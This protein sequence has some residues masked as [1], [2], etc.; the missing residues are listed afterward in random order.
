MR[1]I[2]ELVNTTEPGWELVKDWI[3]KAKN[4]I[5]ILPCDSIKAKDAS[6]KTQVSTRSPMG[7]IIFATGGLFVNNGW[8]RVLGSGHQKLNRSLP[9]WN[10]GKTLKQFGEVAPL[11]LIADDAVGGYFAINGGKLGSDLGKVYYIAPESLDWEPLDLTY[12]DFLNFCFNGNLNK[13]YEH[14]RWK[15]CDDEV[16]KLDGNQ[17]YNFYPPLWTKEGK[18]IS[19][20]SRKV[21]STEEQYHFNI[22]ARKQLGLDKD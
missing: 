17:V 19:K 6:Y 11:L 2:D 3:S 4:K 10:L 9:D 18:S 15:N 12:T 8:I 22:D 5:E 21:I 1:T 16:L 13:F 7:A 14:L 20:S